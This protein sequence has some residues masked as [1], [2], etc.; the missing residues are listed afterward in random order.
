MEPEPYRPEMTLW[1][2]LPEPLIVACQLD[3][4]QKQ[5]PF[6]QTLREAMQKPLIG[7]P[8]QPRRVRVA[9][10]LHA[11]ELR[12]ALPD[13]EV[14]VAPTPEL[15]AVGRDMA[16][17]LGASS[18]EEDTASYL[19]GGRIPAT[20]VAGLFD[21]ARL[22]FIIAPWKVTS[23][24]QVLCVDIPELG[25]EA[26]CLSIIGA[27]GQSLGFI[28]FPSLEGFEAFQERAVMLEQMPD[29]P[30][31]LGTTF[32]SLNFERG[33]DLSPSMRREVAEHGWRVAGPQAYPCVDHYERDGLWRPVTER[34]LRVVS[35]VAT[36]LSA[37]FGKHGS[38]A[39]MEADPICESWTDNDGL[40]VRFTAP[41]EAK[42]LF[43]ENDPRPVAASQ[44]VGRN[45]PCPCGS[46]KKYKKCCLQI[47]G[48][49]EATPSPAPVHARDQGL[50]AEMR[51]YAKRRFGEA[52]ARAAADFSDATRSD[53]FFGPWSVYCFEVEGRPI[54]EWFLE[55]RG[56]H[57]DQAA[58]AW[59]LSQQRSWLTVWEVL[60]VEPGK[61][62]TV[63]DLLSGEERRV[64]EVRG[65]TVAVARHALLGRVVD[66]EGISVFCGAHPRPLAPFAAA[67]VLR[68][69]RSKLRRQSAVAVEK[70]RKE[71]FGR[72]LIARW[73]EAVEDMDA[74]NAVPPRLHNTDGEELLLTTD[75]FSFEPRA[76]AKVEARLRALEGAQPPEKGGEA[77]FSF[78]RA[79]NAMHEDWEN[80]IIATAWVSKDAL[81][82]ESNSVERADEMRR[83]IEQ[84]CA[85][86]LRHRAREHSDPLSLAK[87]SPPSEPANELPAEEEQRLIR[88]FK[89]RH[90]SRWPDQ[91]LPALGGKTP[92]GAARTKRGR[93]QLDLL[94]RQMEHDEGRLPAAE[95]FE[96]SGLRS[97]LGLQDE[98]RAR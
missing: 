82:L 38:L 66:H 61:S 71:A 77:C 34:D 89:E 43:A 33:A 52:W 35:A 14:T 48:A 28:L 90:Y 96:V 76:R 79:G 5:K 32:L 39:G 97:Q 47:S 44:K 75:H 13:L 23:D 93:A 20:A 36:S 31:D 4:P 29:G 10:A 41:Y 84:A 37:F 62:V 51:R 72:F 87:R 63:R 25:I 1:I 70:L 19:E 27:L 85:G 98:Q 26:A 60:S 73:E 45:Q 11:A 18:P 16:R 68:R 17:H 67:E 22:L 55:E 46:G 92:R 59:L 74:R 65:S 21:A 30:L 56:A 42:R 2:E 83:R 78:L 81:K 24:D 6:V 69:A 54:A 57:L 91:P 50:V 94:L 80:T 7:P 8:R 12:A 88:D 3:E 9:D 40:T 15:E 86:L 53:Q 58:R 49:S 64:H 95:R